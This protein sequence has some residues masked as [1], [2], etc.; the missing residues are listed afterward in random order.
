MLNNTP[1]S[2]PGDSKPNDTY[3]RGGLIAFVF[4]MSFSLCFFVYVSW[5]YSGVDLGEGPQAKVDMKLAAAAPVDVSKIE[6]PWISSDA[7]VNHGKQVYQ[8]NCSICHGATGAGD[9]VAGKSLV[10][11]A[12]N[13]IEGSWRMGGGEKGL[14][15]VL[16][17]GIAGGSMAAFKHLPK[18]DRWAMVHFIQ[19]I[20]KNRKTTA[21]DELEKFASTAD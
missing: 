4:S 5:I 11:P 13:L 7:L 19:S 12:R 8:T 15:E 9:G 3:N 21:P 1:G 18:S 20:T 16:Q 10:P 14:Y 6:K 2:D 17:N